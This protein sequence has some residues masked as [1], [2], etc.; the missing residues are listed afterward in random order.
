M[1]LKQSVLQQGAKAQVWYAIGIAEAIYK[2]HGARLVVTCITD[3]HSDK[4]A[5]LH[6]KGFAVDMRTRGI[7]ADQ[8]KQILGSLRN[9]LDPLG[10]DVLLE[11]D[12]QPHIHCE[13]QPK[14]GENWQSVE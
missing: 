13:Y 12:P 10:Y 6:P 8:V 1:I 5:S 3:S 14:V 7:A 4:P 2:V 9:I 11:G